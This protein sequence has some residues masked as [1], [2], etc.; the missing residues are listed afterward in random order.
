MKSGVQLS[1][2]VKIEFNKIP[3]E[4]KMLDRGEVFFIYRPFSAV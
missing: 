3:D 4:C 1:S 2:D